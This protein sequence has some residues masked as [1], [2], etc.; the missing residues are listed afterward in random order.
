M[1]AT[2][3]SLVIRNYTP[4]YSRND[5]PIQIQQGMT[6]TPGA[7]LVFQFDANAWSSTI[8]FGSG[9]PVA[10]G[11][12]LELDLAAGVTP[13]SL[14]SDH[15]QLFDWTGVSPSGQFAS[16]TTDL[17]A[18]YLWDTSQLYKTGD[19]TLIPPAFNLS[20]SGSWYAPRNWSG[21]AAPNAIGAVA[22]F[23]S[24]ATSPTT[25]TLDSNQTVGLLTLNNTNGYTL[26]AG[27]SGSLTLAD[28]GG[29]TGGR[30]VVLAART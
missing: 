2:N 10:L 14:V 22:V 29:T 23:G 1:N 4:Q 11:G 6:L 3:P 30:I 27:N 18:G 26:A 7:S 24:A 9:I 16:I 8:S 17:P 25:V 12:N 21:N 15:F 28:S 13:S 20:G 5:I 19:V